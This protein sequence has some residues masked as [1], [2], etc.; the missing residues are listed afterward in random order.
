[1]ARPAHGGGGPQMRRPSYEVFFDPAPPKI[2]AAP[3]NGNCGFDGIGDRPAKS[4][5]D[6]APLDGPRRRHGRHRND[7]SR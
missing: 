3:Q 7:V 6:P 1:M 5:C 4:D 2:V